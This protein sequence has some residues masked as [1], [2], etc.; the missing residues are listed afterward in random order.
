MARLGVVAASLLALVA[1]GA[2]A[3]VPASAVIDGVALQLEPVPG[4]QLG[5][6]RELAAAGFVYRWGAGGWGQRGCP[7]AHAWLRAWLIPA[8]TAQ[9]AARST[10]TSTP[11]APSCCH[12]IRMHLHF[13]GPARG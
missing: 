9:R 7:G 6:S 12:G 8:S 10:P 3:T 5:I 1:V 11:H 4:G 2:A 13:A